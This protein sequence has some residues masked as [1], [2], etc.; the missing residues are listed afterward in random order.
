MCGHVDHGGHANDK[1]LKSLHRTRRGAESVAEW[2]QCSLLSRPAGQEVR[3]SGVQEFRSSNMANRRRLDEQVDGRRMV[4][5]VCRCDA[6][7][8]R[9]M[10]GRR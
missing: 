9:R 10:V 8:W 5:A 1:E 3:R 7:M 2:A 4:T 6:L